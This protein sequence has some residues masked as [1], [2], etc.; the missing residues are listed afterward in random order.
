MNPRNQYAGVPIEFPPANDRLGHS[1][2]DDFNKLPTPFLCVAADIVKGEPVILRKGSL[3]AAVRAVAKAAEVIDL[4]RHTGV[5]P[6]LGAADVVP[7]VPVQ[8]VSLED[9]IA[10]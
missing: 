1:R 3:A 7:F 9:C 5:H 2:G 4:N 10:L 8:G 6:R